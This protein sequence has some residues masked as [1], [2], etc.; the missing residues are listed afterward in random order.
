M[1]KTAKTKTYGPKVY[2]QE[3]G[4]RNMEVSREKYSTAAVWK[5]IRPRKE[6]RA[7]HRLLWSSFVLPKHAVIAWM[8][9]LN[10]L[11][12]KDR[13]RTWG[14]DIAGDCPL[15]KQEQETRNHIFFECSFSKAIWKMILTLC[16]LKRDVS[17]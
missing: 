11:P 14:F 10:R 5:E 13:L 1:E 15:C 2:C 12:T 7:W 3:R 16:E 6:K 9:I 17:S 4:K 8:T